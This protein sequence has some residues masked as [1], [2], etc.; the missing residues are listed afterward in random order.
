MTRFDPTFRDYTAPSG[1]NLA[2]ALTRLDVTTEPFDYVNNKRADGYSYQRILSIR[3]DLKMWSVPVVAAHELAHIVLAH[4]AFL[5]VVVET[6]MPKEVIPFARFEIEAH[7]VALMVT[8][9]MELGSDDQ[10]ALI[11][12]YIHDIRVQ[13]G[14]WYE[15]DRERLTLAAEAILD[16]GAESP[17]LTPDGRLARVTPLLPERVA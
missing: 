12:R 4:T 11:R 2:R 5:Q 7:T 9:E 17:E 15:L 16:A 10:Q 1:W 13:Y 3:P 14:D 8:S 6:K